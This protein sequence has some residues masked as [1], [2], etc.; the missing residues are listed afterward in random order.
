MTQL[1]IFR[2]VSLVVATLVVVVVVVVCC[3]SCSLCCFCCCCYFCARKEGFMAGTDFF[4]LHSHS[5]VLQ[6]DP[7][8]LA[9]P[10][11]VNFTAFMKKNKAMIFVFSI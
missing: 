8:C 5:L 9:H 11:I 1:Y 4:L 3:D 7:F 2:L 10:K 6:I